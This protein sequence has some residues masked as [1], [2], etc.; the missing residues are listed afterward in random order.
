MKLDCMERPGEVAHDA[1]GFIVSP[2]G[3]RVQ[4]MCRQHAQHLIDEY[5]ISPGETWTFEPFTKEM[6]DGND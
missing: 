2:E 3:M 5:A 6:T 4:P 1:E